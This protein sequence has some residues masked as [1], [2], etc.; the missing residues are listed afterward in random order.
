[1]TG[2]TTERPAI[3]SWINKG[4]NT[5]P[6]WASAHVVGDREPNGSFL[7]RTR[8]GK[9]AA[10]A[11]CLPGMMLI[12]RGGTV[13]ARHP[14]E[15]RSFLADLEE[16][17]RAPSDVEA[18][19]VQVDR[20]ESS[21]RVSEDRPIVI[22]APPT[23]EPITFRQPPVEP[24]AA[25]DP[26][27]VTARKAQRTS[28]KP[29]PIN[30]KP[31]RGSM[32]SIEWVQSDRLHVDHSYQR[33]IEGGP[34]QALIRR[35]GTEWDWRL[36]APL[37]VSRRQDGLY[38]IDGQHRLEGAKLRPDVPQLPCSILTYDSPADEAAMFISVNR[39]RRAMNRLDDFHAALA[40]A[41]GEALA[42]RQ[43]VEDA[44]LS[45]ARATS[46]NTW[47]PGEVA[48]TSA[49]RSVRLRHGDEHVA[50]ILRALA[51]A[52]PDEVLV[53]G[54]ALFV[55]LSRMIASSDAIDRNRLFTA[56]M[57]F[58]A[59]GWAS[60]IEGMKGGTNRATAMRDALQMAYD[61]VPA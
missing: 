19:K 12:E 40:A 8:C 60:M 24:A 1:M 29:A 34:S 27:P 31:I 51:K 7:I 61:E 58:N 39:E 15:A 56:L 36:C 2:M 17:E 21:E 23:P 22:A 43:L 59:E 20:L 46:S 48:F 37:M 32:P 18:S 6:E 35:I 9:E 25:V 4:T 14:A 16:A 5:L 30:P 42:I 45:I 47:A 57:K 50:E 52:F 10:Q 55:G 33:S 54:G 44:G 38:V 13:Y 49:I 28:K 26:A 53:G 11:R 41:N 3:A